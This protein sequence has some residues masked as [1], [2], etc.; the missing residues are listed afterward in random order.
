MAQFDRGAWSRV[1]A[2]RPGSETPCPNCGQS[3]WLVGRNVAEC[4]GCATALPI[5]A[6]YWHEI[7]LRAA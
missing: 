6:P 2:Y 7:R 1:P 4:A 5:V 3:H